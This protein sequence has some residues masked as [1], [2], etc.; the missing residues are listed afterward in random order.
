MAVEN[1]KSNAV[2]NR[3]ATPKVLNNSW[4]QGGQ[5]IEAV[6][7]CEAAAAASSASTY[8]FCQVPSNARISQVLLSS[9]DHGTTGLIDIGVYKSTLD[10]G[11]VV[12]AD[13]FAS[14]VDIKTAALANSDITYEADAADAAAGFGLSD[15]EKPLWQALGLTSDPKIT[16]DIVGTLT[17]ASLSGGTLVLKVRYVL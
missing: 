5:L 3:D 4:I 9:D 13:F 17:E 14:A 11:T 15:S 2:T 8:H 10:G 1:I 7:I 12:D 6:G 16:Y